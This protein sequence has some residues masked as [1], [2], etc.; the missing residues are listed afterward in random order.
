[1]LLKVRNLK[2]YFPITR[3]LFR[4][5]VGV[6][7]AVDDVNFEIDAG[8]VLG[9]VGESGSGK[10]TAARAAIRL[11][12][13]TEGEITF[14]GQNVMSMPQK[15]LRKQLRREIQ[16]VFQDPFASLNP[17]KSIAESLGEG[18]IY[19]ELVHNSTEMEDYLEEILKKIGLRTDVLGRYPHELS[20][21]QQQRICI[22]RAIAMKPRLLICDEAV[23]ALDVSV[24]AQ[25]LNLL[26]DLKEELG[27][28]YLFIS[29]DL[30]V[31]RY[32]SKKMIVMNHGKIVEEGNTES[33]FLNPQQ[34]YTK[35]L[36]SAIPKAKI[37]RL[38]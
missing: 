38:T 3:G 2:K 14:L 9:L 28:S 10:S 7:K 6:I 30:S 24:R 13:P 27:L 16:I 21:G 15:I 4:R 17:R 11:I 20:G 8:E 26:M 37:T 18:L 12:E 23:S 19:H 1:M 32:I 35:T 22:G 29:H 34:E 33:I 25:I 31:V 5:K 36:L